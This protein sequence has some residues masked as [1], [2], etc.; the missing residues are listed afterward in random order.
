MAVLANR[1]PLAVVLLLWPA[2]TLLAAPRVE[3]LSPGLY[4]YVSDNDH[5]ANSTFLVGQRGILV[6]DTGLDAIEGQ[7]LLAEIRKIS[8]LPVQFIINTHYHPDHQGGNVVVGPDAIVISSPFTRERTL[9]LIARYREAPPS[10]D[11]S[12]KAAVRGAP[13]FAFRVAT[14]TL[15]QQLTLYLD[16]NPVE[17]VAS[18][19]AHT[20]GDVYVFFPNQRAVATGDL[21]MN[22]S[23]PA[24]D[25]GSAANWI[26]TL[27]TI[28]ALPAD[29][30]VPGH[31]DV[32]SRD[33]FSRFRDYLSS[34]YSQV[35][36]L[37][38]SGASLEQVKQQIDMKKFADFR[39]YPQFHATFADNAET[40]YH[41][42][43]HPR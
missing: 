41:Q 4:A 3:Q 15:T 10:E 26:H 14:E 34:L 40:I 35:Q 29:H 19:P 37:R 31:F 2:T 17:I 36:R 8:P 38:A 1:F 33:A 6:V 25:E 39:Q 5:S 27:D 7:K 32:A 12:G 9:Q 18:G 13:Q 20:L 16:N 23:S 43:D 24:M 28:S 42:L 21:F 30:F 22:R 11:K